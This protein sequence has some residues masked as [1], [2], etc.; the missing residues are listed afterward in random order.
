MDIL[1]KKTKHF[2]SHR[3][4][5]DRDKVQRVAAP[6]EVRRSEVKSNTGDARIRLKLEKK[7]FFTIGN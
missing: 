1:H 7:P 6:E 5:L 3:Q 2:C 4:H